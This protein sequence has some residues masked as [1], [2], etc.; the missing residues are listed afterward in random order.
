MLRT[1]A[2]G[3]WWLRMC[4][5]QRFE[6]AVAAEVW[7]PAELLAAAGGAP[8]GFFPCCRPSWE[9]RTRRHWPRLASAVLEANAEDTAEA[10]AA[11]RLFEPRIWVQEGH[12]E[13]YLATYSPH[14]DAALQV[15]GPDRFASGLHGAPADLGGGR[16]DRRSALPGW[17]RGDGPQT[18]RW[19]PPR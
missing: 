16:D 14:V 10:C 15:L 2:R 13:T 17:L 3:L 11:M 18:R 1:A 8:P 5:S 7:D 4:G 6:Q 12:I 19:R 9:H